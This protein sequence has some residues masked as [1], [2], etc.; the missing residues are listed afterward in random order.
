MMAYE[1]RSIVSDEGIMD[2]VVL[3][4]KVYWRWDETIFRG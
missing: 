2:G 1:S 4:M 3:S